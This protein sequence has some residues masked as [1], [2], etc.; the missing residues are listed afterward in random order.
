MLPPHSPN[1]GSTGSTAWGVLWFAE[2]RETKCVAL[3]FGG[4]LATVGGL[5]CFAQCYAP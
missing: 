4:A 2:V 3:T 5:A 1:Q